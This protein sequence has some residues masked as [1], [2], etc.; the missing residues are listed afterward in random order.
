MRAHTPQHAI[1]FDPAFDAATT[2]NPRG[3]D[4]RHG[5]PIVD[6]LQ[7]DGVPCRPR[8]VGDNRPFV[9][10]QRIEQ[11]AL[12]HVGSPDDGN[13]DRLAVF[14]LR[15]IVRQHHHQLIQQIAGAIA[16]IG[17]D[18][19]RLTQ[20]QIP[21]LHRIQPAL[22]AFGLVDREKDGL[23][24]HPQ[25]LGDVRVRA[26]QALFAIHHQHDHVGFLHRDPRLVLNL[27]DK[28]RRILRQ[29]RA[30]APPR[31]RDV[32]PWALPARRCRSR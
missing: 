18:G 14:F 15:R 16:V 29:R 6:N 24:R 11:A 5:L 12:A 21:E 26:G 10:D 28:E 27:V 20:P 13:G 22:W 31:A 19:P 7:V 23:F 3:V 9:A 30:A 8:H 25:H 2:A 4:E 1:A 17:A 32:S